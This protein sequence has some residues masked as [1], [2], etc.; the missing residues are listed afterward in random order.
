MTFVAESERSLL[1]PLAVRDWPVFREYSLSKRAKYS[2]GSETVG[3]AW[4][5]FAM[6]IGHW[7][8]RGYAPLG[9]VKRG[10]PDRAIGF[11][12]PFSP[13]DWPEPELGWHIWDGTKEGKGIVFEAVV[14]ARAWAAERFGWTRM[15]SYINE[16]N[17]RSIR[18]AERLGCTL[19]DAAQRRPDNSPVWRHPAL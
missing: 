16:K 2:A 18:L 10:G 3:Q 12:G 8:L 11:A 17:T 5:F 13:A 14:A 15:V 6:F 9:L 7:E 19:D 4:R 1:H